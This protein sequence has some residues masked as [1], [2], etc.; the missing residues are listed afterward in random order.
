MRE[1]LEGLCVPVGVVS[2]PGL[3]RKSLDFP[4][5]QGVSSDGA[6]LFRSKWNRS[7]GGPIF[8][9]FGTQSLS[10]CRAQRP[11]EKFMGASVRKWAFAPSHLSEMQGKATAGQFPGAVAGFF[12][13]SVGQPQ[14][15][16]SLLTS[17]RTRAAGGCRG[18]PRLGALRCTGAAF[19]R[20]PRDWRVPR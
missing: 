17:G 4:V 13:R 2:T 3:F 8:R 16:P 11:C 14:R 20:T 10:A 15:W 12:A 6:P 19:S 1:A 5:S 18:H 7:A 9:P